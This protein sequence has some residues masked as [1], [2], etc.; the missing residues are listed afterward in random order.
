M[1]RLAHTARHLVVRL[2]AAG[3]SDDE[4]MTTAAEVQL[5]RV[6]DKQRTMA[7]DT[8]GSNNE[9]QPHNAVLAR[10]G[11]RYGSLHLAPAYLETNLRYC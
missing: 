5:I 6:L 3:G 9:C 2:P 4:T 11:Q 10:H 7:D 8:P 1:E